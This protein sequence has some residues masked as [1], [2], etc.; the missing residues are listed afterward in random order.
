MVEMKEEVVEK[1]SEA[2]AWAVATRIKS[3]AEKIGNLT[4]GAKALL[5]SDKP[6]SKQTPEEFTSPMFETE[7][8]NGQG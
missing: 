8:T 2:K 4:A 1:Q 7:E 6:D 3:K 5:K